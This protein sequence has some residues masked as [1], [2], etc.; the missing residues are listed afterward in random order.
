MP[1]FSDLTISGGFTYTPPVVP[2]VSVSLDGTVTTS[3]DGI[4]WTMKQASSVL[5]WASIAYGNKTFVALSQTPIQTSTIRYMYSTD[6][7]E[8]WT[9]INQPSLFTG[10]KIRYINNQFI[11]L[12]DVGDNRISTSSDGITWTNVATNTG[13]FN[14]KDIVFSSGTYYL[15]VFDGN[16]SRAKILSSTNLTTWTTIFTFNVNPTNLNT[17]HT[18]AENNGLYV[19]AGQAEFAFPNTNRVLNYSTNLTSW[20]GGTGAESSTIGTRRDVA[21]GNGVWASVGLGQNVA[22]SA[23]G[24]SWTNVSNALPLNVTHR[25]IVY[26]NNKFV[27]VGDNSIGYST[28]GINWS[29]ATSP[30]NNS[31]SSI[32]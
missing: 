5:Q 6:F 1:I 17:G 20:T 22:Y 11:A 16:I 25:G 12:L 13:G 29:A 26:K 2:F 9:S 8:S 28:D 23:D 18:I 3:P 27:A 14:P 7:G 19:V 21:Y 30:Q 4:V 32:A 31:W 15:L 24:Q 10:N